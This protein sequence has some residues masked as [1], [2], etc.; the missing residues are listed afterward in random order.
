MPRSSTWIP[1]AG[2]LALLLPATATAADITPNPRMMRSPDV[3]ATH[4]VFVYADDLWT[5]PKEGGVATP[6]AS[7]A[8]RESTPRFSP[9][10]GTIGFVGNYDGDRDLYVVPTGG[11]VPFRVTHH[12]AGE[13][14]ADW[15]PDGDL[16]FFASGFSGIQ[17]SQQ[18]FRVPPTGGLPEQLP[19]PY[20]TWS[21]ISED[22]WLAYTPTTRD[23]RTWKRY[24]G[25]MATDIWLFHL[26]RHEARRITDWDGTDSQPMWHGE[27]L[28][29]LSDAG[30]HH[31]LNIWRYDP[32]TDRHAQV[33]EHADYDVKW[34]AV[35]PGSDGKGE[36][37]YQHGSELRLLDLTNGESHRVEV[38]IPGARPTLRPQTEDAKDHIQ[39]WSISSTGKR[40]VVSAR[41]DV[42]TLPAEHGSPRNLTRSDGSA[43][44]SPSW[45]PDGRW[46][47]YFGDADGEYDLWIVQSDGKGEPRKL[48]EH[49]RHH[50]MG[51]TWSPDSEKIAYHDQR[52]VMYLLDVES[53]DVEE[54]DRDPTADGPTLRWSH[55]SRFITYARSS[56]DG[57]SRS[58]RIHSLEE[59]TTRQVTSDL[60]A[61]SNPVFDRKGDH[62]YF[63]SNRS[64]RPYYSDLDT[65]FIYA[66]TEV[67]VAVPLRADM[68]SPWA[69]ESD[70]ETWDNDEDTDEDEAED[71][72][73][74][75][76][77]DDADDASEDDEAGEGDDAA[78]PEDDGVS[79]TWEGTAK[80]GPDFPEEGLPFTLVIRV[81][82]DGSVSGTFSFATGDATIES[83][84]YDAET[85]SLTFTITDSAG[86]SWTVGAKI[87]GTSM[88]GSGAAPAA[89]LR[90]EFKA[91]R[92]A[93]LS[94]SDSD[95]EGDG[96]D[97]ARETVTIDFED[98]ES[99]AM[100]LPVSRGSFG[101]LAVNDK[102]QLLYVRRSMRGSDGDSGIFLFDIDDDDKEE[103]SVAKG[104]RG[105]A[106]SANG[107]KILTARGSGASIQNASAGASGESVVTDGML[108]TV[109]PRREWAQLVRDSW[110]I[111]RDYFYDPDMH[112]VDWKAVLADHAALVEDCATRRDVSFVIG[113]MISEL[114]VGHAYYGGG[115]VDDPEPN[116]SVGLLGVDFALEDGAYR[117]TAIHHGGPW[118]LDARGPLG[119]PGVDVSEGDYLLAVNGV[120]LSTVRDP[121]AAFI[122]LA[123]RAT[124]LTVSERPAIDDDAREVIVEPVASDAVLRYRGWIE[125]NR[126]YVEDRTD[127]AVGYVYVPDT[128]VNGQND[129]VRQYSGQLGKQGLIIDERWNGGG[130]IPTRF[131]EMLNRPV[132]NYWARP[133]SKDWGWPPDAHQGPK[134]M[135]INGQAGS[136]GDAFPAYFRQ[137]GLGKLIGMRT[138][139]GLVGLSGNPPL[140]DGGSVRVPTFGYYDTDGTWG[141]E[142]YGV[143]PDIEVI[144]DPSK[145]V[146][147]GDP[148]LDAA[149]EHILLEIDRNPFVPPRKPSYPDR[150]GMGIPA[151]DH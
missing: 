45:S 22:G 32:A 69:P 140:I 98:F 142:G 125:K 66:D 138:W 118:D 94:A 64:F 60:F 44:R 84:S 120:P 135:L 6:L 127:G 100:Q 77:D 26:T 34:P 141:I 134:C 49:D 29:Y 143:A 79:G 76:G 54:F 58:I 103:K 73:E 53:G 111:M 17:R 23:H 9:D 126:K 24:M 147:G 109:D 38:T 16:L 1:L 28:Y 10:G 131:I 91:E 27:I 7:P 46:I 30:P 70:E 145:M 139:G 15:T 119:Q 31:R 39:H 115:D 93:A 89:G 123:G 21:S 106:I 122:G 47:A 40:A 81:A 51:I 149:I 65:T 124:T 43:E 62:L 104:A 113:E 105:F 52:G 19:V 11:G 56:D 67:L 35:G 107:K 151:S 133:H 57:F 13:I 150:S 102:N 78:A 37:V 20:G 14:L 75:A 101:T 117:I 88:S 68:K 144:D 83:G 110:R 86:L 74:E 36:I 99:R 25:G 80:G 114:N 85:G 129:L 33:T 95:G 42:W 112:G 116:V 50:Y 130:Q 92:T 87:T 63:S 18:L 128:G 132:T 8:G 72:G 4:I 108:T 90:A 59:G 148:Q 48:T 121:W 71:E 97:E 41:G 2:L 5:V 96:D 61:D 3:S 136:G 82:D 137:A 12:P 146:D 55:D